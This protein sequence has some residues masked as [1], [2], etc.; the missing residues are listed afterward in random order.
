MRR[1][2]AIWETDYAAD[3]RKHRHRCVCCN[4]IVQPGERVVM[5]RINNGTK[6][7]HV[8]C[9]DRRHVPDAPETTRDIMR[10]WGLEHQKACG[11]SVPELA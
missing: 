10:L 11:W 1:P 9:A 2:D 3:R 8:A 7:A 5:C 4:R 6:A